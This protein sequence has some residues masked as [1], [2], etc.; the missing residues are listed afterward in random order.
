MTTKFSLLVCDV[1]YT[2]IKSVMSL[3]TRSCI[4]NQLAPRYQHNAAP[5]C[6]EL[7]SQVQVGA[8]TFLVICQ[9]IF[10]FV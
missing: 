10:I 8:N 5:V 2:V 4:I 9:R 7:Y 3:Y 6:C 1:I